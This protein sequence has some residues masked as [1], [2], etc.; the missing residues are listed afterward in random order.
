MPNI[1][2]LN[3]KQQLASSSTAHQVGA[4]ENS[5]KLINPFGVCLAVFVIIAV[6]VVAVALLSPSV[7]VSVPQKQF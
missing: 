4:R 3:T 5:P 2:T 7:S 1:Y 6:L